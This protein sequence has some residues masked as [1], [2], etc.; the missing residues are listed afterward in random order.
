MTTREWISSLL[1]LLRDTP[2]PENDSQDPWDHIAAVVARHLPADVVAWDSD[3]AKVAR[4]IT[5]VIAERSALRETAPKAQHTKRNALDELEQAR[6]LTEE[7]RLAPLGGTLEDERRHY[8]S[9]RRREVYDPDGVAPIEDVKVGHPDLLRR[10]RD[11]DERDP[12]CVQ[13]AAVLPWVASTTNESAKAI[14]R[15]IKSKAK[16]MDD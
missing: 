16:E 11:L 2:T 6:R 3:L 1:R 9:T 14:L 4:S 12:V 15:R 13:V 7:L 5:Q 10:A 8:G